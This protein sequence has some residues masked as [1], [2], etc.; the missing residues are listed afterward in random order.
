[1]LV[2][3]MPPFMILGQMILWTDGSGQGQMY[4]YS[5]SPEVITY[6]PGPA[7]T[8]DKFFCC[9]QT[10][11]I[12]GGCIF[13]DSIPFRTSTLALPELTSGKLRISPNPVSSL[14]KIE[15]SAVI[16]SIQLYNSVGQKIKIDYLLESKSA[17]LDM[18]NLS[19]GV[20]LVEITTGAG[21]SK[22]R[23]S[24]E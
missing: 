10:T 23:L 15:S 4:P 2:S 16:E 3:T 11:A 5:G 18:A 12:N 17:T 13:C 1:M 21:V 14:T 20:Y 22:E 24:K 19:K 7:E 9:L 8:A 6:N